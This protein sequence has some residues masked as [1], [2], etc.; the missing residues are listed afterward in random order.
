MGVY[1]SVKMK[2]RGMGGGLHKQ[3]PGLLFTYLIKCKMFCLLYYVLFYY[4]INVFVYC[5]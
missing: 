2:E 3:G 4:V 1:I 5:R